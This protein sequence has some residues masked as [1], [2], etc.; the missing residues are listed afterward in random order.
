MQVI[1]LLRR[2]DI[3]FVQAFEDVEE[4]EDV[5]IKLNQRARDLGL[6]ECFYV[7]ERPLLKNIEPDSVLRGG[8]YYA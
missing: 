4:C 7:E 8:E 3:D 2:F 6:D 5:A 1:Y